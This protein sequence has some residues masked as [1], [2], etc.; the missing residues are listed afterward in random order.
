MNMLLYNNY[1]PMSKRLLD[2]SRHNVKIPKV[3]CNASSTL[4][5][6]AFIF[7]E[8]RVLSS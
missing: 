2:I 5:R 1:I 6:A 7:M 4:S 3:Y 8:I